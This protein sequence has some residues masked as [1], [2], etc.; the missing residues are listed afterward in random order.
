MIRLI[1]AEH[2]RDGG[3]TVWYRVENQRRMLSLS[4][5]EI[6]GLNADQVR[7]LAQ[8]RADADGALVGE[9]SLWLEIVP[10]KRR[11]AIAGIDNMPGWADWTA[12]EASQWIE[13]N[14]VDLQSA[15]RALKAMAKAIMYLRN[16]AMEG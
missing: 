14:V 6:E 2:R 8:E 1:R 13:D 9:G 3:I 5:D 16:I 4:A 7:Q 12:A 10:D 11:D 15:K